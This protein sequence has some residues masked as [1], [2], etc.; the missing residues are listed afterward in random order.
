VKEN[1]VGKPSNKTAVEKARI[2][3]AVLKGELSAVDAARRHAVSEQS[4][5][6]WKAIFLESGRAG[7]ETNGKPRR[8]TREAELEAEIDELTRAL[9]E[10]HVQL[11]VYQRGTELFPPS[12]TSR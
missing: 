1:L 7:L 10:A 9:G 5:H 11:R 6:N 2:V 4:I 8:T 3:I 12:R